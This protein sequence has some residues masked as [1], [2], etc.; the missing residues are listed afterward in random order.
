MPG[1]SRPR[2]VRLR[3]ERRQDRVGVDLLAGLERDADR[4]T[5]LDDD[6]GDRRVRADLGPE[7]P[8]RAAD[9]VADA[10]GTTLG[11]APRPERAVDLAHVVVEHD[12]R[13]A[14]ALDPLVRADDPGR[15]HR[16]LERIGL[17]P[18]VEELR[19]AHRHQ[20]DE[21]R[22]LALRQLLEAPGQAGQRQHR[23]RVHARQVGRG[24]GQDRL[25]EAGHLDHQLAVFLVGL[26]VARRPA[27]QLAYRPAVVVDPPQV[28]A[29]PA[30]RAGALVQ[31]SERA[32]ERQ[33]VEA[34]LRRAAGRG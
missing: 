16:R 27:A 18:L 24:D 14:R 3:I 26:G 7:R 29:A 9:R 10:A 19:R 34:V 2:N 6:G 28:V 1:S 30:R 33:D 5:A 21:D 23:P 12:V 4:A 8:R 15:R 20:L 22:L 17:E 11:D 13:G 25:D 31:R 32:V